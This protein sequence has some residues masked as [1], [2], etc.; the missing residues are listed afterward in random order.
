MKLL[1]PNHLAPQHLERLRAIAGIELWLLEI[2]H[3]RPLLMKLSAATAKRVLPYTA[4]ERVRGALEASRVSLSIDGTPLGPEVPGPEVLVA[5]WAFDARLVA[6]LLNA[7]PDLR[8]IHSMVTG[9]DHFDLPTL[10]ARGIQLTS[11]RSV[12]AR[13]IAEFTLAL[14]FADAK[15]VLEHAEATRR[16]R[17][18]FMASRELSE[19]RLGIVGFGAIGRAVAALA[20]SNGIQVDAYVRNME[21]AAAMPGVRL[22]SDLMALLQAVDILVLALP[23]TPAT[24]G[25]IGA[26]QL[27]AMK[28]G[29]TLINVGRGDTVAEKALVDALRKRHLRRAYVDVIEDPLTGRPTFAPPLKHPFYRLDNL[30]FTGYSSSE[31]RNSAQELFDDFLDNLQRYRQGADLQNRIDLAAGY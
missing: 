11:P 7:L 30:V 10:A 16:H 28:P 21:H 15:N 14:V 3:R 2:D 27:A 18:R 4:Y 12:H 13:R 17:A 29:A 26:R 23:S 8:W 9:V 6:R 31:S 24:R 20:R 22:T 25:L 1:V 5:T 19:L